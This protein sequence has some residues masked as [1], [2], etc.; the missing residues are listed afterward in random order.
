[1]GITEEEK[2]ERLAWIVDKEY[3]YTNKI[4]ELESAM[5]DLKQKKKAIHEEL[6]FIKGVL[7]TSPP[8]VTLIATA[9]V[10]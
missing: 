6:R 2:T 7:G 1:M 5:A 9:H 3:R 10:S 4:E 8:K